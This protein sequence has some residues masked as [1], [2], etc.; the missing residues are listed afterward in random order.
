MNILH[1][2]ITFAAICWLLSGCA[3]TSS[4]DYTA[5]KTSQPRSIVIIPPNNRSIEVNAPYVF[6]SSITRPLAEK[7]Y[8][9]FP[10]AV[11]D[12]LF[13]QNGLPT[14]A[15]MN[16]VP[17]DKIR[18]IIDAD[19][20]MYVTIKNWG[21]KYQIIDS[22][23]VVSAHLKLVDTQTGAVLWQSSA[24]AE[25]APGHSQSNSLADLLVGALVNQ[26]IGSA[27]DYTPKLARQANY[28]AINNRH[29]GLLAGPYF[30]TPK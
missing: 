12:T 6:L 8:Y 27:I 22:K 11:I 30:M 24:Y 1:R 10:V 25:H 4:Y 2:S 21:Q 13:K 9:V 23:S 5:L 7:G 20:V 3:T 18:E 14:P 19:A 15:E 26:V 29:S 16:S 28:N 17:L